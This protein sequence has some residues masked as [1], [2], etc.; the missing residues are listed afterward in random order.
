MSTWVLYFLE[1]HINRYPVTFQTSFAMALAISPISLTPDSVQLGK[2]SNFISASNPKAIDFWLPT[3][4]RNSSQVNCARS[5]AARGSF[6]PLLGMFEVDDELPSPGEVSVCSSRVFL[7][8]YDSFKVQLLHVFKYFKL[9]ARGKASWR[10][11]TGQREH[12]ITLVPTAHI[13]QS[14]SMKTPNN[15]PEASDCIICGQK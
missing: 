7:R 14:P 9:L 1:T 10:C 6:G 3:S 11:L 4:A 15:I 8:L 2:S 5:S 12:L 13:H